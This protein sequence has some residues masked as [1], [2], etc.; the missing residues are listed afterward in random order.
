LFG[1]LTAEDRLSGPRAVPYTEFKAQVT[2]KNVAEVF[3]RGYSIE[4]ELKKAASVPGRQ[5]RSYRQFTTE[6][7]TFASDDLLGEPE[8]HAGADHAQPPGRRPG[9]CPD[10][11]PA[12]GLRSLLDFHRAAVAIEE[13]RRAAEQALPEIR[14]LLQTVRP[15]APQVAR[16]EGPG[17]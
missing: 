17:R 6:R 8:H 15:A 1:V 7:P 11:A 12:A 14:E 13:G 16:D 10:P 2:G 4:G 3:A 5:D 9:R